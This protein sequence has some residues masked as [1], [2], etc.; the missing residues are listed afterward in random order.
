[1]KREGGAALIGIF[2]L[3]AA[4]SILPGCGGEKNEEGG[5]KAEAAQKKP[6]PAV[7]VAPVTTQTIF[8]TVELTGSVEP[9]RTARPASSA[10]GPL[11]ALKVREGDRVVEGQGIA[12]LGRRKGIEAQLA[13]LR[14][15]L[16]KEEDEQ[17]RIRT[18]VEKGFAPVEQLE[19]AGARVEAVRAQIAR[20]EESL[21]DYEVTAPWKGVVARLLVKEGDYLPARTPLVEIYDPKSLVIRVAV[22]ERFAPAMKK[23]L[24]ADV[25]FDAYPGEVFPATVERVYPMLDPK[26]RTR[27]IELVPTGSVTMLPGMFARLTLKVEKIEQAMVVPAMAVKTTPAGKKIVLVVGDGVA[28]A[29]PVKIGV[30]TSEVVQVLEGVSVGEMVAVA[31]HEKVKDGTEVKVIAPGSE[32]KEDKMKKEKDAAGKGGTGEGMEKRP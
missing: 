20:V 22:P 6:V 23:G 3:V 5:G 8:R 10:E 21:A 31:G 9:Y 1:M 12:S 17:Q 25:S 29:R 28:S 15:E 11:V 2:I 32:G 14:E 19:R 16:K 26:L 13:A 24:T 18:L 27:L 4:V 30:E 7:K